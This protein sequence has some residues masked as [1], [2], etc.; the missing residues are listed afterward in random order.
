M[1]NISIII[2]TFNPDIPILERLLRRIKDCIHNFEQQVEIIIVDNNSSLPLL[3]NDQVKKLFG[4]LPSAKIIVEKNP[5]LTNA[6]IAGVKASKYN[7]LIFFDDD[8]EP[9]EDYLV[10]VNEVIKKYNNSGAFGPGTITVE[11]TD[12]KFSWLDKYKYLFQQSAHTKIKFDRQKLWQEFYPVGTGLCI[13][14]EIMLYY[15]KQVNEGNYTLSDRKGK[16]LTSGGDVQMVLTSIKLGYEVG[17]IPE[18]KMNHMINKNKS[19]LGYILK[20]CFGTAS[21]FVPAHCQVFPELHFEKKL[22]TNKQILEKAYTTFRNHFFKS[23]VKS[24]QIQLAIVMGEINT[25]YMNVKTKRPS[26]LTTYER[27]IND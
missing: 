21:A 19:Q 17:T 11:Y 2:C 7:W 13:R 20:Q 24:F 12:I 26:L 22:L 8:N 10:K 9:S 4:Y 6:R 25:R 15:I 18:L 16:N 23:G 3:E 27:W 1:N 14:K 5:G